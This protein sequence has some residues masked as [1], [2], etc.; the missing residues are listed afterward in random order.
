[1]PDSRIT[2]E[3]E[4]AVVGGVCAGV[5]SRYDYDLTTVRIV[6]V[7][8]AL[9]SGGLAAA[10]YLAAWILMPPPGAVERPAADGRRRLT[11]ASP[12]PPWSRRW[13]RYHSPSNPVPASSQS[14]ARLPLPQGLVGNQIREIDH[15]GLSADD[16]HPAAIV[17]AEARV[18]SALLTFDQ[19]A[20]WPGRAPI[21][22]DLHNVQHRLSVGG[23][24]GY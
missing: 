12:Q 1:M 17:Q 14:K 3:P 23:V 18:T 5:A 7:L 4:R 10:V 13:P 11:E 19:I 6:T 22:T 20:K 8:I 2:R 21:E 24:G 16:E 9:A 15:V